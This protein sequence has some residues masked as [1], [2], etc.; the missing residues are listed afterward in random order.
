MSCSKPLPP[1]TFDVLR[2]LNRDQLEQFSIV[3]R[4]LKY[5]IERWSELQQKK[6][7]GWFIRRNTPK[8]GTDCPH[9]EDNHLRRLHIQSRPNRRNGS[10]KVFEIHYCNDDI[11]PDSWLQFLDQPGVKPVVVLRLSHREVGNVLNRFVKSFS[12]A[13]SK[14]AFKIVFAGLDEEL[15]EFREANNISGE[16]LGLKK[17]LQTNYYYQRYN[18][19]LERS[20]V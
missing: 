2:Y 1:F 16:K 11:D 7:S 4:P 18:Y 5:F 17:G 12:S 15:T 6:K 8:F 19:T 13:V 20:S 14:N 10:V 3:C 9:K